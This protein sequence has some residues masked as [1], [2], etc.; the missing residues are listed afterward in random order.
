MRIKSNKGQALIEFVLIL[1]VALL[2]V[3]ALI[4]CGRVL[5]Q[6]NH[7][8]SVLNDVVITYKNTGKIDKKLIKDTITSSVSN[9]DGY[10]TIALKEEVQL[11]TPFSNVILDNPFVINT[12][13]VFIYE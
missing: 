8:E 11:F 5:Y 6:K 10:T 12:E 3:F 2:L 4:D 1:P 7:L 9:N 13:R